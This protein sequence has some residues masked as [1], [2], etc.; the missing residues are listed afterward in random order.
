MKESRIIEKEKEL[1]EKSKRLAEIS[2]SERER[3]K[4][5]SKS[6]SRYAVNMPQSSTNKLSAT[7]KFQNMKS[8]MDV[9]NSIA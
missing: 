5:Q 1:K 3:K 7:V 2:K 6:P 4:S 8:Q 9:M